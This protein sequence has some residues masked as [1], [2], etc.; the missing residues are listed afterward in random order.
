MAR[1]H[2]L[3]VLWSKPQ[4]RAHVGAH[5]PLACRRPWL[6]PSPTPPTLKEVSKTLKNFKNVME[7]SNTVSNTVLKM[8]RAR[9]CFLNIV[10]PNCP[11][12][13]GGRI[14][15]KARAPRAPTWPELSD[16]LYFGPCLGARAH[17]GAHAPMACGRPW[18]IPPTLKE[19]S[20]TRR[21]LQKC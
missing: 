19:A 16:W 12:E 10:L 2:R 4:R 6:N 18:L 17:L 13:G 21:K 3:V 15:Q 9:A 14:L 1:V 7:A 11:V 5:A 8:G 20:K